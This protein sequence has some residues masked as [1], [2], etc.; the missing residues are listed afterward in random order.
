M[1]P[2]RRGRG[3]RGGAQAQQGERSGNGGSLPDREMHAVLQG[4][5]DTT[6]GPSVNKLRLTLRCH[7]AVAVTGPLAPGGTSCPVVRRPGPD[8]QPGQR[9]AADREALAVRGG[10]G[11]AAEHLGRLK[12]VVTISPCRR[13]PPAASPPARTTRLLR[14]GRLHSSTSRSHV[15]LHMR[16]VPAQRCPLT[17]ARHGLRHQALPEIPG[18][19][20]D[21]HPHWFCLPARQAAVTSSRRSGA[22]RA[23]ARSC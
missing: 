11:A 14:E 19:A 22:A 15:V 6:T 3:L 4:H 16:G 12:P 10:H 1:P 2:S 5:I 8:G 20:D 17:P 18:R 23:A 7:K 9:L 21:S 13:W